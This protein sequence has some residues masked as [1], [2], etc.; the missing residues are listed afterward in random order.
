MPPEHSVDVAWDVGGA[1][2]LVCKAPLPSQLRIA[3]PPLMAPVMYRSSLVPFGFSDRP[4][5][6][7]VVPVFFGAD[8]AAVV[9]Q[10]QRRPIIT[11]EIGIGLALSPIA[12]ARR[13]AWEELVICFQVVPVSCK[14]VPPPPAMLRVM[15]PAL[16]ATLYSGTVAP[17][18]VAAAAKSPHPSAAPFR[19][20]PPPPHCSPPCPRSRS[21]RH[22]AGK[23][24]PAPAAGSW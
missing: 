9:R 15:P 13:V 20:L 2:H 18:A 4:Y 22:P 23:R 16:L 8:A 3:L 1:G 10:H 7:V 11:D 19:C 14:T 21:R 5:S 17:T 12:A 24:A 6:T